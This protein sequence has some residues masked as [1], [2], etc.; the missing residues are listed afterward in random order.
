[1]AGAAYCPFCAELTVEHVPVHGNRS[2]AITIRKLFNRKK[3]QSEIVVLISLCS[4]PMAFL[5]WCLAMDGF[6][7]VS[8]AYPVALFGAGILITVLYA[9]KFV[10]RCPRCEKK[11]DHLISIDQNIRYCPFCGLDFDVEIDP[12]SHEPAEFLK[13]GWGQRGLEIKSTDIQLPSRIQKA[14]ADIQLPPG[15][16]EKRTA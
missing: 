15:K 5:G 10:I 16:E 3:Q 2:D 7:Q 1:V 13:K 4:L 8:P 11:L 9:R 6:L 12:E 14:N